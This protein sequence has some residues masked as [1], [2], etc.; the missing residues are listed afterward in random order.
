MRMGR[1]AYEDLTQD[2]TEARKAESKEPSAEG[3]AWQGGVIFKRDKTRS[4]VDLI[5]CRQ[6]DVRKSFL[7]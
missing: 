6:K 1:R 7:G 5:L 4:D 2:G 3:H